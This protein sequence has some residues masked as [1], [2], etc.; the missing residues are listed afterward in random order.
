MLAHYTAASLVAENRSLAFPVS[1]DSIPTSAG[2]EDHVS[3]G[4]TA[5][6]KAAAMLDNAQHVVAIEA[7]GSAQG[8]DLRRP[9]EPAAATKAAL[10][11]VR[12]SSPFLEDDRPLSGDIEAIARSVATGGLTGAVESLIGPLA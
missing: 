4:F 2:Q 6:R 1:S 9:L 8:L 10:D 7:L 12:Q 5:A 11:H 3:M